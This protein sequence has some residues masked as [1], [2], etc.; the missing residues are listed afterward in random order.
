MAADPRND[1]RRGGVLT[2][3]ARLLLGGAFLYLGALKLQ[4]PVAFLKAIR[5]YHL[6]PQD[7][8]Q[9]LNFVA[10]VLPWAE[11]LLGALLVLGVAVRG[12]ALVFVGLLASFTTAITLRALAEHR[13]LGK[14]FC[15]VAFDCGCG[16]GVEHVCVKLM[17]NAV[18]LVVALFLVGSR[19]R[20]FCL[21]H[22][23]FG[24]PG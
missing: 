5:E 3:L 18:L 15:E 20:R 6:V 24:R 11:V 19:A 16:T 21:R 10:A 17:Q 2:L 8:P 23:L 13:E 1:A 12:T 7:H 14:A 22:S 4:D 9:L